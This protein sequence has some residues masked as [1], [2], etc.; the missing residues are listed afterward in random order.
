MVTVHEENANG[1]LIVH[2][3]DDQNNKDMLLAEQAASLVSNPTCVGMRVK[4]KEE[5]R[6][7]VREGK[8][9]ED[10][11]CHGENEATG[12]PEDLLTVFWS[13]QKKPQKVRTRGFNFHQ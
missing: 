9:E 7:K 8:I 11:L 6:K 1:S 5:G 10:P 12:G 2:F 13:E 4:T 3:K